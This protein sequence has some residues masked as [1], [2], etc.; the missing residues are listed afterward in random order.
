VPHHGPHPY[1]TI[2]AD[3]HTAVEY[4]PRG[5]ALVGEVAGTYGKGRRMVQT[6]ANSLHSPGSTKGETLLTPCDLRDRVPRELKKGEAVPCSDRAPLIP[7]WSTLIGGNLKDY[8]SSS[9]LF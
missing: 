3:R 8:V 9:F 7:G 6:L 5:S 4:G 2:I 1:Q